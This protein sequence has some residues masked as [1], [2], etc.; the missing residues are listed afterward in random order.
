VT[1]S[2]SHSSSGGPEM[3]RAKADP[4]SLLRFPKAAVKAVSEI[5]KSAARRFSV[6]GV[7]V[8]AVQIDEVIARM[9]EWI[10]A[11]EKGH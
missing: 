11:G 4:D 10:G 6:V 2:S 7:N 1:P 5:A 8:D 9:R 3:A